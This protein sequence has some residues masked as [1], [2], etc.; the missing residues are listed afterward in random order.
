[1]GS[2]V[3]YLFKTLKCL[4]TQICDVQHYSCW[5]EN[6]EI[7]QQDVSYYLPK[8]F[9]F[10]RRSVSVFTTRASSASKHES[11]A[12]V[13]YTYYTRRTLRVY[14]VQTRRHRKLRLTWTASKSIRRN[15]RL[16]WCALLAIRRRGPSPLASTVDF[17]TGRDVSSL[18][19]TSRVPLRLKAI[20]VQL[21]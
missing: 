21:V 14:K 1:V 16:D 6:I 13:S 3:R 10:R 8:C 11:R 15:A 4:C 12:P 17:A 18:P 20:L 9:I 2:Y 19:Q 5:R 7:S